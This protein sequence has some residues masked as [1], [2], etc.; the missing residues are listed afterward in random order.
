MQQTTT[1]NWKFHLKMTGVMAV[2]TSVNIFFVAFAAK[3]ILADGPSMHLLFGFEVRT[4][5]FG[6]FYAL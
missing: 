5:F 1:I 4:V 6:C 2:L 3:R